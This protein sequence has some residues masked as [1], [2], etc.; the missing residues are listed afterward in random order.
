M[1]SNA[2]SRK[3]LLL[4]ILVLLC[5][6]VIASHCYKVLPGTQAKGAFTLY[7]SINPVLN[8][9]FEYPIVGWTS[10]ESQGTSQKYDAVQILGPKDAKAEYGVY[11]SVGV[12]TLTPEQLKM[13][14]LDVFLE[15][16]NSFKGFKI[17]ER[18]MT[19]IQGQDCP[20][21]TFEHF[22]RLPLWKKNAKD[23]LVKKTIVLLTQ[24]DRSYRITCAGTA[25]QYNQFSPVFE[26]ALKTFKL[27]S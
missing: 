27:T 5:A 12:R 23:V 3:V 6:G 26:R 20:T 14:S 25:E 2:K 8:F 17:L 22:L 10:E 19:R 9:S 24:G 15:E 11:I 7:K 16:T 4:G 1:N 18:K 21:A 13:D